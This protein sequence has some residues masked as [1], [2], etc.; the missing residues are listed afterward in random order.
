MGEEMG[1]E[2]RDKKR[3]YTRRTLAR[4]PSDNL[5]GFYERWLP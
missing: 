3:R 2:R 5:A 1:E 4:S